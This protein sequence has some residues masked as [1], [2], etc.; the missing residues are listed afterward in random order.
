MSIKRKTWE[1]ILTGTRSLL[2][3]FNFFKKFMLKY[4]YCHCLWNNVC[5]CTLE[6]H[7]ISILL[8]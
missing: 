4:V 5:N 2:V 7:K 6:I 8:K 1:E 3:F